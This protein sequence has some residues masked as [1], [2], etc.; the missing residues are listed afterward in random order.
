MGSTCV[1]G[2]CDCCEK[3]RRPLGIVKTTVDYKDWADATLKLNI[4]G[5]KM[6]H[7]TDPDLIDEA[8]DEYGTR[9]IHV[10]VKTKNHALL[11]YLLQNGADVNIK[12]GKDANTA[13]HEAV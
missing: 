9:A 7:A 11:K 3:D 10:A 8:V 5:I 6:L 2:F 4:S 13:L 12:G 1:N